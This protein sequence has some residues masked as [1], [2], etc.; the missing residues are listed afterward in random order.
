MKV[1]Y[2]KG[3]VHIITNDYNIDVYV[4]S[5]C[6]TLCKRFSGHKNL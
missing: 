6:D 3:N 4:G 2:S 1:D 5:T